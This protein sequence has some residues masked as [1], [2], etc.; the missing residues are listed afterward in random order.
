MRAARLWSIGIGVLSFVLSLILGSTALL[1]LV[2]CIVP[3]LKAPGTT[4]VTWI[5]GGMQFTGWRIF[6]PFGILAIVA[7]ALAYLGWEM[8]MRRAASD[9]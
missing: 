6:L 8:L 2:R 1:V 3:W 5:I 9:E 7:L 4:H